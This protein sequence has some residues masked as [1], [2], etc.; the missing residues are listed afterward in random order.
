MLSR[1]EA[2]L[3][4]EEIQKGQTIT[5]DDYFAGECVTLGYNQEKQEFY[6]QW[7]DTVVGSYNHTNYYSEADF[8]PLVIKYGEEY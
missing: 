3:V 8:L 6:A 5:Y 1:S 2:L 4:L 7:I